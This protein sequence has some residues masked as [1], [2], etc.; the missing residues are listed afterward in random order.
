MRAK[1][2]AAKLFELT[3]RLVD[4]DKSLGIYK[5]GNDNNYPERVERIINNSATAKPAAKLF[6][7]YIVGFGFVGDKI[8]DFVVNKKN[9]ITLRKLLNGSGINYSY[10]NGVFAHVNYNLEGV[11]TS[12][13]ILP[14]SHC[15]IGKKDDKN[16]H[17]KILVYDNWDGANGKFE[18]NKIKVIDVFNDDPKIVKAQIKKAG[19]VN[20]Y[21]GQVFFYNPEQTIYPLAHIDNA[22][23]DADSEYR[24]GIFKNI[25]LRKGF[26]GKQ[27]VITPPMVGSDLK[28]IRPEELTEN[29][30]FELRQAKTERE[31]FQ[32]QIKSF[33]G[34]ENG[35]GVMH[36]E[37]E[38]GTDGID[39]VMKFV[40]IKTNINDKLFA[41]TENSVANNIR[42]AYANI[43]SILIENSDNSIFGQSGE[44]LKSAKLFYQDQTEDD[45]LNLVN[46]FFKPLLKGF[47]DFDQDLLKTLEIDKLIKTENNGIAN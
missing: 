21:K 11:K 29:Q 37:M 34:S 6:K 15:R 43:P 2:V 32:K 42:K 9:N 25:S 16:Y 4:W 23:N 33:I 19:G 36:M 28:D 12:I 30:K 31:N 22:M 5:N 1:F 40:E 41:H 18:K 44:M 14:Y 7:K 46:E 20:K 24:V 8:N 17:G 35:D 3:K 10:Q 45:R 26:F 27:L 38:F 39:K 47:K 13:K